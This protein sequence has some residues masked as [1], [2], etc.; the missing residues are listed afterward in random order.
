MI[1]IRNNGVAG[2][3]FSNSPP[4]VRFSTVKPAAFASEIEGGFSISGE[5]T[6]SGVRKRTACP[7]L[8]HSARGGAGDG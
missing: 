4:E 7:H 1:Q 3:C 5:L 8:G 2:Q 6:R